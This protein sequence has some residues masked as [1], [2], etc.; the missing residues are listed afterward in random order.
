MNSSFL[1]TPPIGK[2][3]A[4]V[5]VQTLPAK[6]L[7][8]NGF[9]QNISSYSSSGDKNTARLVVRGAEFSVSNLPPWDVR[10]PLRSHNKGDRMTTLTVY[11][12]GQFW[13]GVCERSDGDSYSVAK[14]VFGAEPSDAE[15]LDFT[16]RRWHTLSFSVPVE[17]ADREKPARISPKRLARLVRK[18]AETQGIG[19]KAQQ[20]MKA[21][22]ERLKDVKAAERKQRKELREEERFALKQAKK[23]EKKRGH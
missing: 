19:T 9:I 2:H 5:R 7:E 14:T 20:A 18:E 1:R 11:Y 3:F 4:P 15:V 17:S 13:V 23:K 22:H 10:S 16:L 6:M 12:D 8:R 21:E